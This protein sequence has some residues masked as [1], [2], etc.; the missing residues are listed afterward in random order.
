M[1]FCP[2][3][4]AEVQDGARFCPGCGKPLS[5]EPTPKTYPVFDE[6]DIKDNRIMAMFSYLSMLVILPVCAVR[7]SA[8]A[9]Y[10]ANQGLWLIIG[11]FVCS[12]CC[13]VPFLGWLVG[14]VGCIVLFVFNIIGIVRALK[15]SSKP[16]P[17]IEKLPVIIK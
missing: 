10:H 2:N 5:G 16:L 3:C 7:D 14:G 17:F 15:G 11:Y 13:I 9:M 12:V 4:G 8:Y 6:A 1:T